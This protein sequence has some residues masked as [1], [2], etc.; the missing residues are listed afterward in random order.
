MTSLRQK[1]LSAERLREL[2]EYRPETGE[3]A[4]AS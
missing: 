3:F 1:L 2:L 4:R